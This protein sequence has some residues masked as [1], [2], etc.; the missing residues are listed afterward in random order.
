[1]SKKRPLFRR[2]EVV[3]LRIA[4]W[5]LARRCAD[6]PPS[7]NFEWSSRQQQVETKKKVGCALNLEARGPFSSAAFWGFC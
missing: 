5:E 6:A 2:G 3:L 1:M 4:P 7:L